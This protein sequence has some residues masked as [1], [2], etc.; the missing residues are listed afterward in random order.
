VRVGPGRSDFC[1]A[2]VSPKGPGIQH[3]RGG[4]KGH[5]T[6]QS[7]V[8]GSQREKLP[9]QA[10]AGSS[11]AKR[12]RTVGVAREGGPGRAGG[13]ARKGRSQVA[14]GRGQRGAGRGKL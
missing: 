12:G 10:H 6:Q 4:G 7:P 14:R 13:V 2:S 1:P 9:S 3:Q 5:R 8:L 11:L